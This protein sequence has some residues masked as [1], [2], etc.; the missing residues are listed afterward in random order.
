M[1]D[2]NS[3][4]EAAEKMAYWMTTQWP[5]LRN[6]PRELPHEG[7][8]LKVGKERAARHMQ[9]GDRVFLYET[10]TG[11]AL[12]NGTKRWVGRQGIV[13]LAEIEAVDLS[14]GY[15]IVRERYGDGSQAEWKK[16]AVTRTIDGR[17]YCSRETVC[18]CLG[19]SPRYTL[20]GY[21]I[22]QSGLQPLNTGVYRRLV[23]HFR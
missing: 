13:A 5:Q 4:L 21:G 14:S 6:H 9:V 10:L 20:R 12:S 3:L 15:Q 23:R 16:V 2:S 18:R 11:K 19:L 22:D 1:I 8:W 7:I 17:H